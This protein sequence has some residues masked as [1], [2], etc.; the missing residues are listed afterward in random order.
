MP[1]ILI[2][3]GAYARLM[4]KDEKLTWDEKQQ[5]SFNKIKAIVAEAIIFHIQT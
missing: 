4:K 1:T 3:S 2:D 5:T